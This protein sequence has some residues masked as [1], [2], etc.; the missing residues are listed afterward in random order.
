MDSDRL[1]FRVPE[2]AHTIGISRAKAYE[3]ISRGEIPSI[4]IG[5]AIRVPT[6]A[7]RQWIARQLAERGE[8][9]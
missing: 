4:R 6:D 3:L 8:T 1:C 5:G 9:R 2:V 7:L